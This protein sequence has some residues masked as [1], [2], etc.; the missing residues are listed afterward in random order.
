MSHEAE[1]VLYETACEYPIIPLAFGMLAG[2]LFWPVK[3]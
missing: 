3:S 1:V 2:H